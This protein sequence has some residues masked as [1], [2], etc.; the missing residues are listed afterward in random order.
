VTP[1]N[2][3]LCTMQSVA[4]RISYLVTMDPPL[5]SLPP[6]TAATRPALNT[7]GA[8]DP[9]GLPPHPHEGSDTASTSKRDCGGGI[10]GRRGQKGRKGRWKV[11]DRALLTLFCGAVSPCS[12]Q[13]RLG[14]LGR[15]D[16]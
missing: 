12:R 3:L 6:A 2:T 15:C 4:R 13:D 7:D 9:R 5:I 10:T 11:G 14:R 1:S 8:R 16:G